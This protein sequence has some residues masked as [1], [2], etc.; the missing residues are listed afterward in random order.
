MASSSPPPSSPAP[1]SE[2][3]ENDAALS[4]EDE[5]AFE[6]NAAFTPDEEEEEGEELIGDDMFKYVVLCLVCAAQKVLTGWYTATTG[7]LASWT[8]TR[9]R[10]WTTRATTRN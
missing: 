4:N 5:A 1:F 10:A 8:S 7:T 9:P 3:D 2:A 6:D